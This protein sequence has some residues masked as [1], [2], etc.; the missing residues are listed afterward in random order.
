MCSTSRLM[1]PCG[2]YCG[3]CTIFKA[4]TDP[5]ARERVIAW[6]ESRGKKNIDPESIGCYGC[7]GDGGLHWSP[8]CEIL[9]CTRDKGVAVCSSCTDFACDQI[10]KWGGASSTHAEALARLRQSGS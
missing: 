4:T 6:L 8:D 10:V 9:K 2:L 7:P 1:A 5:K 3:D